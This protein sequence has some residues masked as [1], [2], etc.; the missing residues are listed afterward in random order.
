M[1]KTIVVNL[2][3]APGSGKSTGAS[4]IFAALKLKGVNAEIATEFAKEKVWEENSCVF[5]CQP[6]IFGKQVYRLVRLMDKVDVIITDS[7]ILLCAYYG[8]NE[9]SSF[10]WA[11]EDTFDEYNN[12]NYFILRDKPYNPKGR[13]QNETES[14][15]V[16]KDLKEFLDER[17]IDYKVVKGSA[18]GYDE[19]V[20]DIMEILNENNSKSE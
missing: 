19:I 14:N 11:V 6:Y 17:N 5:K 15:Q 10:V 8:K 2:F 3:G 18:T 13:F 20:N 12:K 1:S 4:Y 9:L 16:S 7:P